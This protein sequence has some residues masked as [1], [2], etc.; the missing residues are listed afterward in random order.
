MTNEEK[1][2]LISVGIND[3]ANRKG[4]FGIYWAV[5]TMGVHQSAYSPYD[6][7]FGGS[8]AKY[9]QRTKKLTPSQEAA[10]M[11]M[12]TKKYL[13]VLVLAATTAGLFGDEP[14]PVAESEAPKEVPVAPEDKRSSD[15]VLA[16]LGF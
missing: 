12:I 5:L 15:P 10:A 14:A 6:Q 8:V 7:E 1:K 11:K 2:A 16:K 9:L 13:D 3:P 4:K